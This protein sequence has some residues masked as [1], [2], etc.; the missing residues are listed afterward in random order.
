MMHATH[1]PTTHPLSPYPAPSSPSPYH[2]TTL[3]PYHQPWRRCLTNLLLALLPAP[4]TVHLA[5]AG[6]RHPFIHSFNSH[7]P[8]LILVSASCC[9]LPS[10]L[11][12]CV[13]VCVDHSHSFLLSNRALSFYCHQRPARLAQEKGCNNTT[14]V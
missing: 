13:C 6:R 10:A 1:P 3:S 12:V 4:D 14:T 11:C 9:L 5:N 7:S 2:P 8:A